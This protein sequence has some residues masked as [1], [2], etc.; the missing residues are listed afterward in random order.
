M[1]DLRGNFFLNGKQKERKRAEKRGRKN[2]GTKEKEEGKAAGREGMASGR[3][4]Q[5]G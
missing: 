4:G 1:H 3:Q 2:V 5:R